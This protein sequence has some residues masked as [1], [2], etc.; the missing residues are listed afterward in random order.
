MEQFIVLYSRYVTAFLA[1]GYAALSAARFFLAG[2]KGRRVDTAQTACIFV[3]QFAAF[4]TLCLGTGDLDVLFFYAFSQITLFVSMMLF[5]M[6]YPRMSRTLLN[7]M[8]FLLG[9]G[10]L[11]LARMN[12]NQAARQL[13]IAA[14]SLALSMAVPWVMRR[15]GRQL[16][17][18]SLLYAG[19]GLTALLAVL[20]LGQ[21]THG[22][23][24]T[25]TVAGITFQPSEFVKLL[26]V[27]FL[28]AF[29]WEDASL[30]R[31]VIA[32]A[33]AAGHVL[34]LVLS[35]D[36]GSALIFFFV[37]VLMVFLA[38]GKS[39]YLL[40]GAACGCAAACAA[41]SLFSHVRVRVQAWRDP[42]SVIDSQGYQI[43]QSLFA[44]SRGG[45]FGL[46][47][48]QGTPEDIP[49]VET[50]FIF[51]ALTEELGLVFAVSLL[52]VCVCCFLLLLRIASALEDRFYRFLSAGFGMMYLFQVFL[53]VGGGIRFIPLT[54]V[55][56]PLV[57]YGGS[58]VMTTVFLFS[59][60]QGAW[61]KRRG[62]Q[63]D[64]EEEEEE[65]E[66]EIR[67]RRQLA[68]CRVFFGVLFAAMSAYLCVY[69]PSHSE[70]LFNNSYNSRQSVLAGQNTR[71]SIYSADGEI[72]AETV[73]V[74]GKEVRSYP[75]GSL[76]SHIVGYSTRGKTGLE[77]LANYDLAN[78]SVSAA[79]Q[80]KNA[81]AGL[82]NPGNSLVTTLDTALQEAA[83]QAMGLYEGA[84]VVMEPATG[85]IFA[86]VSKPD[87]DP[88]RISEEWESLNAEGS[89]VLL[90]RASQG[91]YPP[92][93]TFK[94]ITALEYIREHPD[95][96]QNYSYTCS[97]SYTHG[98][99]TIRCFHGSSHGRLDFTQSFAKS[100]NAS[101]ANIGM[102]L[103]RQSFSSTLEKLLFDQE[104][105]V[106]IPY[107]LSH[108][109]QPGETGSDEEMIQTVIG[110][111]KTQMTPLHL[112]MLTCAIANEGVLMKPYEMDRV[113]R[114]DGTVLKRYD[115]EEYGRLMSAE[116]ARI[117]TGLMTDV[118]E[119]GTAS[120]LSG[121]SY[122]AAGK[123]GS[124]EYSDSTSDSHAWFTG[125][126][127]AEDPQIAVTVIIEGIGSGGDYAVP[128]AK[129]VF[130]AYFGTV[131]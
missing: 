68:G 74:E 31:L 126:A 36:L 83:S 53:T 11:V 55:T 49:Y 112:C 114:P 88:N 15:W 62:R 57:S 79:E 131:G 111:G 50:D 72:L 51:A 91:I 121:L 17:E 12:L 77:S 81:A 34:V 115:P 54:G 85:K 90:N 97:G 41:Y 118:V 122:T 52:A 1:V 129:R 25:Y 47:I 33:A 78:T 65:E 28:A 39:R 98:E 35:R 7:H 84:I 20:I 60:V 96:W 23:R 120:K 99:N 108:V 94:I 109:A 58:S 45:L 3:W 101:F 116:E 6:L 102:S 46:G 82:K 128:I 44:L 89:S 124:A 56:L 19:A 69:L 100:C 66:E 107:S 64:G 30:K 73:A 80:A 67:T 59:I 48:G 43:T 4:L 24:I 110:Q 38:T 92:G 123:T 32:A 127:P 40:A 71:G 75:F 87:F 125:F 113:E 5:L 13:V 10:F 119:E 16:K 9:T 117:L 61:L 8:C 26:F 14:V 21:V 18:L 42:W 105:P 106:D 63:A 22:S 29:L 76:F 103:D 27:L 95:D 104:L 86:M 93:S 37:F 130:D 70:E 2:K